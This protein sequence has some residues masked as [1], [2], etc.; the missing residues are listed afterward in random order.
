[1]QNAWTIYCPRIFIFYLSRKFDN[2]I[3]A[4]HRN[5]DFTRVGELLL[6]F[7]GYIAGHIL[8]FDIIYFLWSDKDADLTTSCKCIGLLNT[9]SLKIQIT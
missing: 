2:A 9:L 6:D 1:M 8:G 3:L 4:D 7:L 5:L